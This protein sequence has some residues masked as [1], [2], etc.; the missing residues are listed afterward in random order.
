MKKKRLYETKE[1]LSERVMRDE[2]LQKYKADIYTLVC[3]SCQRV[4]NVY[5]E[6]ISCSTCRTLPEEMR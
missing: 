6:E 2:K 1:M 4:L 5:G 3:Q